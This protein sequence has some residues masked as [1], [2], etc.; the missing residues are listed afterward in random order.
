MYNGSRSVAI[1]VRNGMA[2]PQTVKKIPIARVVAA[3]HMPEVQMW[4]GMM[5]ILDEVQGIQAW[6]MTTEQRQ[7][8]PFEKLDL[9]GLGSWL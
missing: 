6:K 9:S 2:Y 5:D 7:E 3:N 4:L 1:M 8:R